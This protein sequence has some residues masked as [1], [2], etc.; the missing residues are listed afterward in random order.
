V[1]ITIA[2]QPITPLHCLLLQTYSIYTSGFEDAIKTLT[3]WT[4]KEKKFDAL[5]KDFEVCVWELL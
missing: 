2:V 1:F 4:K 3:D 5:V